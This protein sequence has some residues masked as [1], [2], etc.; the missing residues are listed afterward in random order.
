LTRSFLFLLSGLPSVAIY[1]KKK[2]KKEEEEP[3]H[4]KK[5]RVKTSGNKHGIRA[6]LPSRLSHYVWIMIMGYFCFIYILELWD[7]IFQPAKPIIIETH[8]CWV[9]KYCSISLSIEIKNKF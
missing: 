9:P 2:K 4:E 3:Y 1:K 8:F 7:L 6:D 5:S